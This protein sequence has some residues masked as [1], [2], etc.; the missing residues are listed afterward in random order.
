[1]TPPTIPIITIITTAI[2]RPVFLRFK[3]G[4]LGLGGFLGGWFLTFW[5]T[6]LL[7]VLLVT[8]V[9]LVLLVLF[10]LFV[11]LVTLF[12]TIGVALVGSPL[13]FP[14]FAGVTLVL[15]FGVTLVLFLGVT[16]V[17]LLGVT[18]VLFLTG[19]L[20]TGAPLAFPGVLF[21]AG[22][23]LVTSILFSAEASE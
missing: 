1:M 8:F 2:G 5:T 18:L 23:G 6:G 16:L 17:W 19:V 21:L 22:A 4:F 7:V 9:G 13:A 3:P 12:I 11:M 15:F 14:L 20:L 10:V